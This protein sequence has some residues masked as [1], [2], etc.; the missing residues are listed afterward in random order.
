MPT[1][2]LTLRSEFIS[3]HSN[4]PFFAGQGGTTSSDGFL[5]TPAGLF[6]PDVAKHE[7]RVTFAVNF[8]M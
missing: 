7:N 3:R 8:R 6:V 5:T 2:F 1:D 4:V